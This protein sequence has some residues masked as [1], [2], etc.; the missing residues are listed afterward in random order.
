MKRSILVLLAMG[1]I[2]SHSFAR[3]GVDGGGAMAVVC[4]TAAGKTVELLDLYEAKSISNIAVMQ[5]TGN[6]LEDYSRLTNNSFRLQGASFNI[7]A[8]DHKNKLRHMMDLI[9]WHEGLTK[10]PFLNDQGRSPVLPQNCEL[11]QLAIFFDS[12]VRMTVDKSLWLQLNTMHQAAL[13]KHES[14]YYFE[15]QAREV[16]SEST[17]SYVRQE[18]ATG[19]TPAKDGSG[20]AQAECLS[21]N[22]ASTSAHDFNIFYL[23]RNVTSD[24]GEDTV[25]Q[26][27]RIADRN[28]FVQANA[29][30]KDL[31]FNVEEAT[32]SSGHPY[33]IPSSAIANKI[34]RTKIETA[35]RDDWEL[36]LK[37]VAKQP[38]ELTVLQ[39]GLEISKSILRIC[40]SKK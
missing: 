25:F 21:F 31:V 7:S 26:M 5:P 40:N 35:H 20:S 30:F 33:L 10:L 16:T 37:F 34:L 32:D 12:K 39:N 15:R 18:A 22:G 13:L 14:Y 17:R 4:S 28:I 24:I 2:S 3:V 23:H 27:T 6:L 29:L 36:Q 19:F 8:E 38:I 11:Q 1:T 9:D